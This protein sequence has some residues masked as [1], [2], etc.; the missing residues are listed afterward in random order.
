MEKKIQKYIGEGV[1]PFKFSYQGRRGDSW[2]FEKNGK[3][4]MNRKKREEKK[5][6]FKDMLEMFYRSMDLKEKIM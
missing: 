1:A 6:C 4:D 3:I 5:N 2:I